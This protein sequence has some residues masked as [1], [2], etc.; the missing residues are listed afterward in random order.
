[1]N[2]ADELGISTHRVAKIIKAENIKVMKKKPI[3]SKI[4]RR[5]RY[6]GYIT[7]GVIR[8]KTRKKVK[9]YMDSKNIITDTILNDVIFNPFVRA[10]KRPLGVNIK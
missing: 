5:R 1:M 7:T 3:S 2:I 9:N 4:K 6:D 10:Y 8:S